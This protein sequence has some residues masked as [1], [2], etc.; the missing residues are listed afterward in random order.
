M[1]F[2][3]VLTELTLTAIILCDALTRRYLINYARPLIYSTFMS[4]PTLAAIKASYSIMSLE[5]TQN[6]GLS[7]STSHAC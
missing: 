4:F 2:F 3:S 5:S 7:P 1:C 6:V